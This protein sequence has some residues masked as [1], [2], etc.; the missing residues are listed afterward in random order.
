[1]K[2]STA[3]NHLRRIT[4]LIEQVYSHARRGGL[5][6]E[7]ILVEVKRVMKD[8]GLARCPGWVHTTLRERSSRLLHEVYR[9]MLYAAEA[10]RLLARARAGEPEEPLA[11]V[12]WALRVDGVETTSAVICERR[13]AGD[14]SIWERVE[15]AHVWNHKP[16]NT[17]SPWGS[18]NPGER[19]SMEAQ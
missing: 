7:Y 8:A 14:E 10:E 18:T 2:W 11:Y 19:E 6:H 15:G 13:E 12:R 4:G 16:E 3:D 5:S 17:F 9:P 1:M